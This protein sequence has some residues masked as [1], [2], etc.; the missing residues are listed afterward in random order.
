MQLNNLNKKFD[1]ILVNINKNIIL[2]DIDA[3]STALN[4]GGQILLSGF[5]T[6][7]ESLILSK[8]EKLNLNFQMKKQ[9][10]NWLLLHLQK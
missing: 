4:C 8:A 10:D 7:D 5:Y 3:Y 6:D 1:V 9:K 2:K